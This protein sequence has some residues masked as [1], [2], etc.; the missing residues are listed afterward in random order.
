MGTESLFSVLGRVEN[1]M[2]FFMV[3]ALIPVFRRFAPK[4]GLVDHPGGR[5]KQK[6]P[7]PLVGGLAIFTALILTLYTH[8]L[9]YE[10]PGL[11]LGSGALFILGLIDDRFD[12]N[13]T[14]KFVVQTII[15]TLAL[16]I[17]G[18]WLTSLGNFWGV[19][20]E[21]GVFQYP[22]TILAILGVTNAV[23]MLDG[24][25]GLASGV[26]GLILF[27]ILGLATM[28]QSPIAIF[29]SIVLSATLG[30]WLYNY[31]FP[32]RQKASVFMGDAGTTFLGF[33]LPYLAIHLTMSN[34]TAAP[35]EPAYL[36]WLF[37][38]PLWDITTV[39]L[40]RVNEN[41]SPFEAGRDHIHHILLSHGF[42]VR[43]AV[44]FIYGVSALSLSL[45]TSLLYFNFGAV[46]LYLAFAF[47]LYLYV[48][49]LFKY[50]Q[51]HEKSRDITN[52]QRS[53]TNSTSAKTI[54]AI[55]RIK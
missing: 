27:F 5:K 50:D 15:T 53:K 35:I 3:L 6:F 43:Q 13:A 48:H 47:A 39:I 8:D 41:R 25:D 38:L 34:K 23:N 30:F 28:A 37:A 33:V 49:R 52:D 11:L 42:T 31:R 44:L 54:V 7:T 17:D 29:A 18:V 51:V 46:G 55:K 32:W 36:L 19:K 10:Y 12:L 14:F 4:F 2:A 40:K 45:G 22:L 21:M 20:L 16:T 24:L 9:Y 26:I 1:F